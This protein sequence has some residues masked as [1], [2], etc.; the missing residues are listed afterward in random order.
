MQKW[1]KDLLK[2]AGLPDDVASLIGKRV[3]YV[4]PSPPPPMFLPPPGPEQGVVGGFAFAGGP[5]PPLSFDFHTTWKMTLFLFLQGEIDVSAPIPCL[6]YKR[7]GTSWPGV[8]SVIASEYDIEAKSYILRTRIITA[9]R[10][11]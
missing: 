4:I 1:H 8:W 9:I 7:T 11:P 2:E 5:E 3:E 10:F 6:A